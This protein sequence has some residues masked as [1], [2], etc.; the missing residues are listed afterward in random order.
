MRHTGGLAV[1]AISTRSSP[2]CRG[3]RQR[4][5]RRHDAQ[6][7]P[8]VVDD[9]HL[10]D[11][12]PFVDPRAVFPPGASVESDKDLLNLI[13][14]AGC[15]CGAGAAARVRLSFSAA[16]MNAAVRCAP[17]SP[18]ARCRTPTV[19]SAASRSPTTSM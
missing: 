14:L 10:A 18:P 1:A 5:L 3:D 19:P 13:T 8:G 2:F 9:A 6:L 15:G 4:L 16:S 17:W 11:P 7:L 12:D